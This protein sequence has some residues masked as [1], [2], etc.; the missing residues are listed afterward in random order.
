MCPDSNCK[1]CAFHNSNNPPYYC[2]FTD[3]SI[4]ICSVKMKK[5]KEHKKEKIK[6]S[7]R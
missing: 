7:L 6:R 1:K 3:E 4:V 5:M 2:D